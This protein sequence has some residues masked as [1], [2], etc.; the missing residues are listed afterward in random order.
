M[1]DMIAAWLPD[2]EVVKN[3]RLTSLID[4]LSLPSYDALLDFALAEPQTYWRAA[5]VE[6]GVD[7]PFER[8]CDLS[9]GREH[10]RWFLGTEFNVAAAVLARA[11]IHPDRVA[12]V[13]ERENTETETLSYAGL[14]EL[15]RR[16]AAGLVDEG[17]GK[18]DRVALLLPN[19]TEA[20]ALLL[21]CA[22]LGAIAVPLYSGFGPEAI[23]QRLRHSGAVLVVTAEMTVRAGKSIP[24]AD[25]VAAATAG[26]PE[27]RRVLVLDRGQKGEDDRVQRFDPWK[28]A[29]LEG[30]PHAMEPNDPVMLLY[31]SGTSGTPK[32]TVHT[33]CGFPLRVA[34]DMAFLFDVHP[35]E[36]VFW[37]SD[38][39][40]MI[41]PMLAFG[42]LILGATTVLYEGS[43]A[44]P[45]PERLLDIA[46]RHSVT[47]F[48]IAPT[49][50]RSWQANGVERDNLQKL[51]VLMSAGEILDGRLFDYLHHAVNRKRL[52]IINY[53]GGTEVSG[54]LLSNV[55]LRPIVSTGFN[56]IA[57]GVDLR[58]M[59]EPEP[60]PEPEH[61]DTGELVIANVFP[62][63]T[64]SLWQDDPA[65][66][67]AYWSRHQGMWSH[68]DIVTRTGTHHEIVGRA[69][70]VIKVSGRRIGPNEV[71]SAA[72]SYPGILEAAAIGH[73]TAAGSIELVLYVV[74]AK[75]ASHELGHGL[76]QHLAE[77]LGKAFRP[78]RICFVSDLPKTRNGKI[79]R[80][81]VRKLAAGKTDFDR[82]AIQNP[83]CLMLDFRPNEKEDRVVTPP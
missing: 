47:H 71:E 78:A 46:E 25:T 74:P 26:L 61:G 38:M 13:A 3:A 4:R 12:L 35:V 65:Y 52:P 18:G 51:R 76:G 16:I 33:H 31:T 77:T 62:G 54:G 20:A 43:P 82:S 66:I 34:H 56:S 69:D 22:W 41:G 29:P 50:A 17:I 58:L 24:L 8:Y 23:R 63:M 2:E 53:T 83:E 79:L 21:A 28:T 64:K 15:T 14:L 70:D 19:R 68:G 9:S 57:P 32:G 27:L 7:L 44:V 49:L 39:G 80:K 1:P 10:P 55:I 30:A 72:R 60:E 36:R 45:G 81:V 48:G 59:P 37:F 11:A 75:D 73:P 6:M 42:P 40:W 5:L 67:E